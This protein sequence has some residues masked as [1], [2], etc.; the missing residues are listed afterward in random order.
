MKEWSIIG[1]VL[2]TDGCIVNYPT[3]KLVAATK[4]ECTKLLN[5]MID[6]QGHHVLKF[7]TIST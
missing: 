6:Q 1:L 3:F 2:S 4:A 5:E 7:A